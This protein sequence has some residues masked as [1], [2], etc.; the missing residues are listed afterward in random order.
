MKLTEEGLPLF[1]TTVASWSLGFGT[2]S[3]AVDEEGSAYLSSQGLDEV[4]FGTEESAFITKV[5]ADGTLLFAEPFFTQGAIAVDAEHNIYLATG[6][7]RDDLPVTPGALQPQNAD[8]FAGFSDLYIAELDP[9]A[10][11]LIA[12]TYLGGSA[13]DV[14]GDLAINPDRPGVVYLTGSTSSPDFPVNAAYQPALNPH[15]R[16]GAG[17]LG[18]TLGADGFISVLDL[19][20][21]ELVASTYLGG[22]GEERLTDI[23]L[24]RAP[25]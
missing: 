21:M 23:A 25:L 9:A 8:A 17:E 6:T 4:P 14:L 10:S 15:V 20:T 16:L 13:V 19:T 22:S 7:F 3:I 1:D 5:D 11:G 2:A 12:A 18:G 24:D